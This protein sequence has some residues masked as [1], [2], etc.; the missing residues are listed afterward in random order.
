[1]TVQFDRHDHKTQWIR[2]GDISV[3]W[4]E[5]QRELDMRKVKK[6]ADEFDPDAVGVITV[7]AVNGADVYH[8]I[9][10]QN[11]TAAVKLLWGDDEKVPCNIIPA[12]D[13]SEAA[14]LFLKFNA[15]RTRPTAIAM[16]QAAVTAGHEVETHVDEIIRRSGYRIGFGKQDGVLPAVNAATYIYRAHGAEIL[17][18]TLDTIA[19]MWGRARAA[20]ASQVLRGVALFLSRHPNANRQRLRTTVSR[21]F[22]A[23]RINGQARA[24]QDAFHDSLPENICRVLVNTYN[25]NLSSGRLE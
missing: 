7:C 5:A 23:D 4:H 22:S 14:E 10:G 15:G 19:A 13:A 6:I 8:C 12:K 18:E 9:D 17:I 1:M 16:F 2:T 11:R 3:I 24:L 25:H 20:T 21:R